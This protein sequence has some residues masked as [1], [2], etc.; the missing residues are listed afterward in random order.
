M[1][2]GMHSCIITPAD[3]DIDTLP[4]RRTD[5][6]R[7]LDKSQHILKMYTS[8]G[9]CKL[10]RRS[11]GSIERQYRLNLGVLPVAYTAE[12]DGNLV[13]ILD[14]AVTSY[15]RDAGEGQQRRGRWGGGGG[16]GARRIYR[17]LGM[18]AAYTRGV[19]VGGPVWWWWE[20]GC[21]GA[22]HG[23]VRWWGLLHRGWG[24]ME[25]QGHKRRSEGAGGGCFL[26]FKR[27][28]KWE[29]RCS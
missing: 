5:G 22:L 16:G 26:S 23:V 1:F 27:D 15:Q 18:P 14:K 8:D 3:V 28:T 12:A 6:A 25:S 9:G 29:R 11:N 19:G 24:W 20:K 7:I 17:G 13:Y 21:Q 2:T 10:L 4:R